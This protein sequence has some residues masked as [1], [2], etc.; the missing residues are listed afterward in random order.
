MSDLLFVGTSACS[1]AALRQVRKIARIFDEG[2]LR[3]DEDSPNVVRKRRFVDGDR[4]RK[5]SRISL[6]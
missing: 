3:I 5:R 1:C 6:P 4:A 2:R